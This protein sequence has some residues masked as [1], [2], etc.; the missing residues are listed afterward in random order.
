VASQTGATYANTGGFHTYVFTSTGV[1][2]L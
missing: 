1:I 2:T